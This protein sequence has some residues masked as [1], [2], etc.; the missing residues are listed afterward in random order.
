MNVK[1]AFDLA[2]QGFRDVL[3]IRESIY[4]RA[5]FSFT[6]I[7]A[8][9]AAI[10]YLSSY[11]FDKKMYESIPY[12]MFVYVA[13]IAFS[14]FFVFRSIFYLF[15]VLHNNNY[16]IINHS[17]RFRRILMVKNVFFE[18]ANQTQ[19]QAL[20][21]SCRK[22][23]D[24]HLIEYSNTIDKNIKVNEF[25]ASNLNISNFNIIISIAFSFL[26]V[27]F[28]MLVDS[29]GLESRTN[30]QKVEIINGFDELNMTTIEIRLSKD[31]KDF[32]DEQRSAK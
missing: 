9:S 31:I 15:K 13:F 30:V 29:Q 12:I 22:E 24:R 14:L 8:I 28:Y 1:D 7:V 23:L 26:L 4:R 16:E 11:A 19:D 18:K 5:Q 21:N 17:E 32:L 2:D 3:E 6:P 25:R 27:I 10:F 20:L